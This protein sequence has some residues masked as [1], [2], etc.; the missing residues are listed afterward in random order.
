MRSEGQ[1]VSL[2]PIR[3]IVKEDGTRTRGTLGIAEFVVAPHVPTPP[4]HV[5]HSHEEGFYV[6]EGALEF[7]VG[8]EKIRADAGACVM[9]PIGVAHTF[10]NIGNEAARFLNPFTPPR[11]L[12]Y[13]VELSNLMST[14]GMPT[15]V[16]VRDLMARYDTE[17][18]GMDSPAQRV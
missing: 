15:P 10:A 3:M 18:V 12:N 9:V 8:T 7:L 1:V 5:H 11:Y 17:V 2:G 13:F 4:L 16:Q 6:L 14:P